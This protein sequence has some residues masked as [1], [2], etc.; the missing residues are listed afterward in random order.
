MKILLTGSN[1]FLGSRILDEIIK[2]GHSVYTPCSDILRLETENIE[3]QFS[4]F[5]EFNPDMI[6]H[7]AAISDTGYC[8]LHENE[9]YVANVMLPEKIAKVSAKLG[10]KLISCS[11][12]QIYN[13]VFTDI[14]H[15][16]CEISS[17]FNIYGKHKLDAEKVINEIYPQA[18]SLRLTWMYDMP[19][20][21][22]RTNN[23]FPIQLL[24][25]ALNNHEISFSTTDFR[26]FTY[27]RQVAGNILKTYDLPGGVYNFGSEN[28]LSTYETAIEFMQSFG[29]SE[30]AKSKI[31]QLNNKNKRNLTMNCEKA[32]KH[33]IIFDENTNSIK[34][35][36]SDY[37]LI[38]K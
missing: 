28:N 8:Q 32:K 24:R 20:Y 27:A 18:V 16:E 30:F 26:G 29:M 2:Q 3:K 17:P 10:C 38:I 6:I 15:S 5:F 11:S 13:G 25:A 36:I 19:F 37:S 21:K 14:P 31:K 1:G 7:T 12:D 4:S 35:M 34:Q 23:N 33:G 22:K 9:S